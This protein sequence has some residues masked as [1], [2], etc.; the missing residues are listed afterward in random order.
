MATKTEMEKVRDVLDYLPCE[1]CQEI[2]SP[3]Q[4]YLCTLCQRLD[5]IVT[6]NRATP[7][8]EMTKGS[9]VPTQKSLIDDLKPT[10]IIHEPPIEPPIQREEEIISKKEEEIGQDEL[11]R[12]REKEIDTTTLNNEQMETGEETITSPPEEF[13]LLEIIKTRTKTKTPP[14]KKE[15]ENIPEWAPVEET[16][17]P[18]MVGDYTLY[19]KVVTLRGDRKQRLYFFSKKNKKEIKNAAAIKKPRG[20]KVVINKKTGLPLLKKKKIIPQRKQKK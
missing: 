16:D 4:E 17:N 12:I 6:S 18:F 1:T 7:R 20:Y 19:T 10:I 11:E 8:W 3:V 5:R 15:E 14:K 13:E 2:S 9:L